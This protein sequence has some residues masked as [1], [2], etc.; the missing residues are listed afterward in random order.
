MSPQG[1][2]EFVDA[3]TGLEKEIADSINMETYCENKSLKDQVATWYSN[4]APRV[5]IE[6][7]K[8]KAKSFVQICEDNRDEIL[9]GLFIGGIT[10]AAV[11]TLVKIFRSVSKIQQPIEFQGAGV[12][13]TTADSLTYSMDE[14]QNPWKTT[15]RTQI[16]TTITTDTTKCSLLSDMLSK[17]IQRCRVIWPDGSR[18]LCMM[19]P[20]RGSTWIFPTHMLPDNDAEYIIEN[21]R[22]DQTAL[23]KVIRDRVTA[24]D[25][26][27]LD[28][29]YT[30]VNLVSGGT[31]PNLSK[32]LVDGPIK[33]GS[34][35]GAY[36]FDMPLSATSVTPVMLQIGNF[37]NYK[38]TS[39]GFY[40]FDYNM[41][42]E[43][44]DGLCGAPIITM[45]SQ[46]LGFHLAGGKRYG[47]AGFLS[48]QAFD[49]A[50]SELNSRVLIAHSAGEFKTTQFGIEFA[51][52][53]PIPKK[54]AV[55]FM[56]DEED[57]HE[58]SLEVYG[59]HTL[60]VPK[61]KSDVRTSPISQDVAEIMDLPREH[62]K[63]STKQIWQHW[64][65]DLHSIAHT[66]GDFVATP[67]NRACDDLKDLVAEM[68][69]KYPEEMNF[70][71]LS[72]HHTIN[73]INGVKWIDKINTSSSMGF[74]INK[75]KSTFIEHVDGDVIG[76]IDPV[77]FADPEFRA[78]FE[79]C[80]IIYASGDRIYAI[81]RGNLKDDATKFS[82]NKIRIFA[83]SQAIFT[84]LVRKY[85]L[86]V[87]KFVQD[88]GLEM[89]CAVGINAFGPEWEDVVQLITKF[90]DDRMIAGDYKAF[91]KSASAKAMMSA[92]DVLIEIARRAGYSDR[93]LTIM[94]GIAT[95][96]C[97]P[98]YEYNGVMLQAFGSNPSGHPLT[99][100]VNNL[101]NSL[102]LRYAYYTLHFNEDVPPFHTRVAALCYGDDNVMNVSPAEDK[103]THTAVA[104]VLARA[105]ITYTMA[106][107]ESESVPLISLKDINFL[108]RG[109][110]FE[111]ELN[112]HVAPIEQ[113]SISK[114]LHNI[115]G[116]GAPLEETAANALFTANREFFLHGKEIFS[117]R[118]AQL[119]EVGRKNFGQDFTLPEW[120]QLRDEFLDNER[121]TVS[122]TVDL[123]EQILD[124]Q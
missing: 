48:K 51:P 2:D 124:P 41:P 62:G 106:D 99:V 18:K 49:S 117:E 105:G 110:R 45:A 85:Y 15:S 84:L 82:K 114:M 83:G 32:F 119:V 77:D 93:D 56:C 86:P 120:F 61:F 79:E 91:D 21:I 89:E 31:V 25:F 80:E 100:V 103:F 107:K 22:P 20:L 3:S 66:R 54:H 116:T 6:D 76:V 57:G 4:H 60:G 33:N 97:Y 59:A 81:H 70:C 11:Y 43:T 115:K 88:H 44:Y 30:L 28:G 14:D 8:E 75:S 94:R 10:V 34:R 9:K 42:Y 38:T 69:V 98:L 121:V 71:P 39:T 87:V 23:S 122:P 37:K 111:P 24:R 68:T 92:F 17:Y 95:D 67:W 26:V 112:R 52:T 101:M 72:W 118:H 27:R 96:I 40:G 55:H 78:Y 123:E 19:L 7:I 108:K 53:A 74:P 65:R 102:Y 36:L 113:A 16:P 29:D 90:G 13:K 63:P 5:E 12:S 35:V 47:A 46:L 73:G 64:Q 104:D 50:F 1:A 58:P 109:F